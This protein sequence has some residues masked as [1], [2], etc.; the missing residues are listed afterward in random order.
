MEYLEQVYLMRLFLR[1][2]RTGDWELRLYSVSEMIPLFHAA[3]HLP[4]ARHGES[5]EIWKMTKGIKKTQKLLYR[6][7]NKK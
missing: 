4:Y 1:A 6:E 3:G 7:K 5:H 2:E